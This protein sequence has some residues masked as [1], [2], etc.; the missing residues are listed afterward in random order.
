MSLSVTVLGGMKAAGR[1]D[2]QRLQ[3]EKDDPSERFL[4]D[5]R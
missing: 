5:H 3:W 1:D 4:E 2:I